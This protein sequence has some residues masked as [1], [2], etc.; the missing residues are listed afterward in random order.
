MGQNRP[1][2]DHG[3]GDI[4]DH[5]AY[6]T[7]SLTVLNQTFDFQKTMGNE[8]GATN[9]APYI[10]CGGS[11]AGTAARGGGDFA[12]GLLFNS[13]SF[14]GMKFTQAQVTLSTAPDASGGGNTTIRKQL[15]FLITTSSKG[16]K[17][18]EQAFEIQR[19]YT[20]AVGRTPV[21]PAY[22]SLY[23]HCKNRYSNQSQLLTAARYLHKHV[24]GQVGVLVIDW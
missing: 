1:A 12:F 22:G 17:P 19:A 24:P 2:N 10:I 6:D 23:W 11:G 4:D 13:P 9:A 7:R 20:A 3:T 21:M 15:D 5:G 16:A 14:G 8:G 18:A